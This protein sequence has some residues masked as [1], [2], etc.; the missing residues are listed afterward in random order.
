MTAAMIGV[1]AAF[2]QPRLNDANWRSMLIDVYLATFHKVYSDLKAM[3]PPS[4]TRSGHNIMVRGA[5]SCSNAATL[6][7]ESVEKFDES[8]LKEAIP[9]IEKCVNEM[10]GGFILVEGAV[11]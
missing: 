5:K 6:I 10:E 4:Y 9:E 11:P 2:N 1:T 3:T 8:K 7:E